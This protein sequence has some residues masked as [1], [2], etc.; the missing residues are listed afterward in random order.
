MPVTDSLKKVLDDIER[1]HNHSWYEEI[2]QRNKQTLSD[3]ALLYRGTKIT[4]DEMFERMRKYARSLKELGINSTNEIPVCM[5]NT[6]EFVY[7]LGAISLIGAKINVFSQDYRPD[8][9]T[10]I[11]EECDTN[12][13]FVEDS[14]YLKLSNLIPA[15][16]IEHIVMFSMSCSLS[17][18]SKEYE[19]YNERYEGFTRN[20]EKYASED[21][22]I[23]SIES[24]AGLGESFEG[25]IF[26]NAHLD[27]VFSITYSSGTTSDTPK[28]IVHAVRS[29][30]TI[31]RCHDPE[32][33]K[34]A[35]MKKF[36][37]Q[38]T[39]PTFSNADVISS[40]SDS[41][42]QGACVALEPVYDEDFFIDSLII[43]KPT[44][45]VATTSFWIKTFKKI[46]FDPRYN[47]VKLPELFIPFAVG[48]GLSRGEERLI[49]K[50]LAKVKAG[51]NRVPLPFSVVKMSVAGGD[52]EHGGIFWLVFRALQAKKIGNWKNAVPGLQAFKMV[53][54]AV[55][56]KN[57]HHC[58]PY[59]YGRLVANSPCTMKEYKNNE[60][61]T[62]EFFIS[63]ASGK[64]WGN[65]NVYS[66]IDNMGG[67][68]MKGRIPENEDEIPCFKISDVILEDYKNIMSCE[69]VSI[70]DVKVAHIELSPFTSKDSKT[71]IGNMVDRCQK[72]LGSEECSKIYYRIH[73]CEEGFKLTHSGKRD[74][75]S[76]IEEGISGYCMGKS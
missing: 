39:I 75:R 53:E 56:D 43:N 35:S 27:D 26:G 36:V 57:G 40:I 48:E 44:Y 19:N 13:V 3:V 30:I 5:S 11:I 52:C 4:Y 42:M 12:I 22:R 63:D 23:I 45:V 49:N 64:I 31:G 1:N 66:Y 38:A 71:I 60:K 24:F 28:P 55:L 74:T 68:H 34:T 15:S 8:Y 46:L 54:Y 10:K 65:C 70:G 6:P 72:K 59:E 16:Q 2:Y 37:I 67:I 33:Q 51:R 32:I 25:E 50:G 9:I 17:D 61:A 20:I 41:L 69:T 76:L 7:L 21:S 73:S 14:N 29:F 47:D 18:D 58:K 62:K